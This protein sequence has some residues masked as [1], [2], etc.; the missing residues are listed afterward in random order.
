[1][2]DTDGCSKQY[3]SGNSLYL[4]NV[5]PLKYNFIVDRAVCAPGHG[6]LIIDGFNAVNKHFLRNVMSMSGTNRHDDK[7]TRMDIHAMTEVASN[8]FAEEC[9]RLCSTNRRKHGSL[10]SY[11]NKKL[12][13][14]ER[15]YYVQ[16]P[17]KVRYNSL[18][19]GTKGWNNSCGTKGNG[20]QHH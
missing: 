7:Q 6:K 4:V 5:L 1:M 14:S 9:A 20:I 19:M 3:R 11:S 15:H 2:E 8:S 17:N 13:L 18:S 10:S 16:D 12:K